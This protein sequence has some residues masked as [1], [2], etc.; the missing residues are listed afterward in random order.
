LPDRPMPIGRVDRQSRYGGTTPVHL[1]RGNGIPI[2]QT[3]LLPPIGIR[4]ELVRASALNIKLFNS[5]TIQLF[6]LVPPQRK[7]LS[8]R[9]TS[10]GG[11]PAE[12][13]VPRTAKQA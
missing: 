12:R 2:S 11:Y 6:F 5:S 10:L 1:T 9:S 7:F 8:R 3:I 4:N 13:G